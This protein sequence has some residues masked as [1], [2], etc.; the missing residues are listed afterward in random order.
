MTQKHHLDRHLPV[1]AALA[2]AA[3]FSSSLPAMAHHAMGGGKVTTAVDGLLSGLAHPVLGTDHLAF[4]IAMGI[5]AAVVGAGARVIGVFM[6]ASLG[7]VVLHL[8]Q[9]GVPFLEVGLAVTV[10]AAGVLLISD[11]VRT[12]LVAVALALV[13]GGLH[14]YAL[15]ESII[16][17]EA[18]PLAAYLVGL[19]I[20]QTTVMLAVMFAARALLDRTGA[21]FAADSHRSVRWAGAAVCLAGAGFLVSAMLAA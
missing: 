8:A 7:G 17:V 15:A 19:T 16:G 11:D 14:G 3:V 18:T 20:V 12:S 4:L 13:G 1:A 10:M 9:I 5:A 6:I 2:A 21:A